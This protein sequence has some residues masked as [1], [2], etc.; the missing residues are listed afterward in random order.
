M[1]DLND[2]A[3][4]AQDGPKGLRDALDRREAELKE[5]DA[6]INRLTGRL[7][8]SAFRDAGLNPLEGM[9]KAVAK[10]YEG[11][12]DPAKIAEY[13]NTEFGWE[14]PSKEQTPA[15]AAF[16]APQQRVTAA[17]AQSVPLGATT[18]AASEIARLESEGKWQEAMTLKLSGLAPQQ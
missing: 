15:A 3:N 6:E 14:A 4:T 5:K 11:D 2:T 7:M 9:G 8:E 16:A 10:L 1:T 17:V 13:A 18:D 12:P